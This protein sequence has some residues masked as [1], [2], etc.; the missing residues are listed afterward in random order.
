MLTYKRNLDRSVGIATGYGL[1]G[2]GSIPSKGTIFLSSIGL[3]RL[4]DPPNLLYS[5]YRGRF[6][7]GVKRHSPSSSA[8]IRNNGAIPPLS[9][10]PLWCSA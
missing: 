7:R 3:D 2:Q 10:M 6:P 4:W 8:E 9:H 5:E 1:D